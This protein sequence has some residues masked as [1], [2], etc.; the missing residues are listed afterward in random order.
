MTIMQNQ[1]NII[2]KQHKQ[3]SSFLND[4]L[5]LTI[6][7]K[8]ARLHFKANQDCHEQVGWK[9]AENAYNKVLIPYRQCQ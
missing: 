7:A 2:A 4:V 9:I 5:K 1:V 8:R 3:G 6:D